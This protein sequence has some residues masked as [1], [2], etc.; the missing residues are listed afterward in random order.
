MGMIK[1]V[2]IVVVSPITWIPG[3]QWVKSCE[4]SSSYIWKRSLC[5]LIGFRFL[6]KIKS[7]FNSFVNSSVAWVPFVLLVVIKVFTSA[8]VIDVW[9]LVQLDVTCIISK[10]QYFHSIRADFIVQIVVIDISCEHVLFVFKLII[11]LCLRF[12]W[13]FLGRF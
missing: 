9:E 1:L 6:S 11:L 7:I 3:V 8:N 4:I 10:S 12:L 13:N 5:K 2:F